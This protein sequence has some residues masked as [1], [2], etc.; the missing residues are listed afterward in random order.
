MWKGWMFFFY[1]FG[2]GYCVHWVRFSGLAAQRLC[3]ILRLKVEL[4]T[5][6]IGVSYG[7][8]LLSLRMVG[9]NDPRGRVRCL[10]TYEE[11]TKLGLMM[12]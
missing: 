4:I 7:L 1:V 8:V 2:C 9:V 5:E 6:L 10:P 11:G 3:L 12:V